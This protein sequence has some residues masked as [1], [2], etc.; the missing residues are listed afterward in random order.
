MGHCNLFAIDHMV[1]DATYDMKPDLDLDVLNY[2]T[3]IQTKLIQLPATGKLVNSSP[4]IA[5]Q[6][7]V[8]GPV[9]PSSIGGKNPFVIF[10]L[11][12]HLF[13]QGNLINSP[14]DVSS[15]CQ[16]LIS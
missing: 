8:C 1:E 7:V 13:V 4:E 12:P 10:T 9:K 5:V 2:D 6:T 16:N 11:A 3:C 15:L 14:H